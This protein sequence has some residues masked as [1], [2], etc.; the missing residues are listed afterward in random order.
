MEGQQSGVAPDGRYPYDRR[1]ELRT[2]GF[3][4]FVLTAMMPTENIR[5][6]QTPKNQQAF[7]QRIERQPLSTAAKVSYTMRSVSDLEIP[8]RLKRF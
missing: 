4:D 2:E 6:F 7:E 5:L 3:M 8:L 1:Q